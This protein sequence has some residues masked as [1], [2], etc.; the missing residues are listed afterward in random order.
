[1]SASTSQPSAGLAGR[2]A[3][4]LLAFTTLLWGVSFVVVKAALASSTPLAFTALRFAIAT[5]V[6]TPFAR[7][8]TPFT[9][10]ELGAGVLLATLLAAGFAAQAI[11][12]VSTTPARSAF[13]VA[14][15]SVLAPI[16]A[17]VVLRE[18]PRVWVAAALA[19]AGAGMYLLTAP[20]VGGLNRGDVWTLGTA[21]CFGG[22]IVAVA[23]LSRRHDAVRLVWMQTVGTTLGAGLAAAAF[24]PVRLDW[25]PALAGGLAYAGVCA[26]ALA[27]LWQMRAQRYMSSARAALIFCLEPVFAA[28]VSWAW[29][30][31][32]LSPAQWVGG[33][34]I[35]SGMV[36]ADL[37]Q[38]AR[39]TAPGV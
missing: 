15:S 2:R 36:L 19:C 22:Q 38:P 6:L 17:F 4:F 33:A 31:E 14:S 21:C 23:E 8:R 1:M 34:M 11:G 16:V 30:G 7:L 18:R 27:L 29:L 12:L 3:D 10:Q 37:P 26:T 35:L 32:R 24:E 39:S 13:I 25:G 28:L 20:D 5:V 9:R